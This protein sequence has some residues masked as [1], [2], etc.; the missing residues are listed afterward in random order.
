MDTIPMGEAGVE[1][2]VIK[3]GVPFFKQAHK[4]TIK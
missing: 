2:G 4:L 1:V 3:F